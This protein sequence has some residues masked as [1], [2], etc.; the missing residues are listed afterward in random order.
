[1]TVTTDVP[2]AAGQTQSVSLD[3]QDDDHAGGPGRLRRRRTTGNDFEVF[4]PANGT[5]AIVV[6]QFGAPRARPP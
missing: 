6:D 1:M 3:L 5:Y 2:A 4:F